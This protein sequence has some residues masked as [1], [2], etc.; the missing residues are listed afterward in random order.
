[1]EAAVVLDYKGLYEEAM[2]TISGLRHE[3]NQL[4]KMIYGSK[5]ERFI[6]ESLQT[7]QL[8]LDLAVETV[9]PETQTKEVTYTKTTSVTS[10][11]QIEHP[12]RSP[13]PAHLRREE[14]I[15]EPANVTEG[16]KKIGEEVTEEL[17]YTPGE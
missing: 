7:A 12:G 5:H 2:V 8:T 17:E 10:K 6:P 9:A 14:T 11:K 4:K 15:L 13:L 1:M 3:L 16:S